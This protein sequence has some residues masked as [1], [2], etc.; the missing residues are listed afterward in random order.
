LA[1]AVADRALTMGWHEALV[2]FADND[3]PRAEL[4]DLLV[5]LGPEQEPADRLRR[6][7]ARNMLRWA[8]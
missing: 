2:V 8:I 3:E 4:I 5:E 7:N 1:S 6:R